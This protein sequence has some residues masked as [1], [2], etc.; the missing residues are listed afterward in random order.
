M[1]P[2]VRVIRNR[3]QP[4]RDC[5]F[6]KDGLVGGGRAG[7]TV[8]I[9]APSTR[10]RSA[11]GVGFWPGG[12]GF[13]VGPRVRVRRHRLHRCPFDKGS[14][15]G[16]PGRPVAPP[17][18]ATFLG[19]LWFCF[20]PAGF[21]RPVDTAGGSCRISRSVPYSRKAQHEGD[22]AGVETA[23]T[24]ARRHRGGRRVGR[25]RVRRRRLCPGA[26]PGGEAGSRERDCRSCGVARTVLRDLSQPAP[27]GARHGPG[28]ARQRRLRGRAGPGRDLGE[29]HQK[30]PHRDHASPG[31]P[32][33]RCGDGRPPC[34]LARDRDRPGRGGAAEPRAHR[35][36]ASAES[37][38]VS[39]RR[40]RPPRARRGRRRAGAGR[41]SELRVRQYRRRAEGVAH[42]ARTLHER[43]EAHQPAGG[44]GVADGPGR[45]DLP[46][47]LRSLPVPA[48]RR[49]AVRH[50]RR[51]LRDVQLPPGRR[52]RHRA[53]AA[54]PVRRRPDSRAA[55]ARGQRGRRAGDAVPVGAGRPGQRSG[56]RLQHRTRR[57]AGRAR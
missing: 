13:R 31:A 40:P 26:G 24:E 20:A 54:R 15:A 53:R 18:T 23:F 4:G 38:R 30:G 17:P 33:P 51:P 39:E 49:P 50:P 19:G 46:H 6:A 41:R 44:G 42:P 57:A 36:P 11:C 25:G 43:G 27:D 47:R 1:L 16:V 29:G 52:V 37:H 2:F 35:S 12:R 22:G 21:L 32:A 10:G 7:A 28:R 48:P 34:R 45:R 56:L 5:S 9:G 3:G 55:P 8:V 14:R